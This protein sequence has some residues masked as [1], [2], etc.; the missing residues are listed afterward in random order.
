MAEV[1]L[2]LGQ[3]DRDYD[4]RACSRFSRISPR[5]SVKPQLRLT[6]RA[7][8]LR[9]ASRSD[10]IASRRPSP[11]ASVSVRRIGFLTSMHNVWHETGIKLSP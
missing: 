1:G 5:L 7:S 2:R 10:R 3:N 6:R 8:S 11:K 4:L 9:P